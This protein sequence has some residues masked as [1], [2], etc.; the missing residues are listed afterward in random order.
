MLKFLVKILEF[1]IRFVQ[2][3]VMFQNRSVGSRF[4]VKALLLGYVIFVKDLR[5][6]H[7]KELFRWIKKTL[8]FLARTWPVWFRR[9]SSQPSSALCGDFK[10]LFEV[11]RKSLF[12]FPSKTDSASEFVASST[13]VL[14][15]T[16]VP[17]TCL[18]DRVCSPSSP[19]SVSAS[20]TVRT[21]VLST[22]SVPVFEKD[23][24]IFLCARQWD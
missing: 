14:S 4:S 22:N 24:I 17:S 11:K 23:Y 1:G 20:P 13:S 12:A 21:S 16:S 19:T 18:K 8:S 5:S 2:L 10:K 7:V 15:R 6:F 9:N 3:F